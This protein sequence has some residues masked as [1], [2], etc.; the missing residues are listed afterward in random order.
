MFSIEV[1]AG[2][3]ERSGCVDALE[4]EERRQRDD[5]ARQP[6]LHH[7]DAVDETDGEAEQ[8]DERHRRPDVHVRVRREVAEQQAGA[9]DHH[10]GRQVELAADHQQRDRYRDDPVLRRLVGPACGD[11]RVADPVDGARE[12]RE[13][14]EDGDRAEQRADVGAPEEPCQ[15]ADSDEAFV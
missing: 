11:R 10:A 7:R 14:E 6:G 4:D 8:Q 13:R 15:G 9:A 5:E 2:Q 3:L 1:G 12:V